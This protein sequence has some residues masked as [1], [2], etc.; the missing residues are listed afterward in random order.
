[1]ACMVQSIALLYYFGP[2][3]QAIEIQSRAP[4]VW[5]VSQQ[6]TRFA[7]SRPITRKQ[8]TIV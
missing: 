6:N 4:M 7:R 2:E 1:M 3:F 5:Y 8:E